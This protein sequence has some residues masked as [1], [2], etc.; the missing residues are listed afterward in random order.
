MTTNSSQMRRPDWASG[1]TLSGFVATAAMGAVFAVTYGL[2]AAVG[3]PDGGTVARWFWALGHNAMTRM[4]GDHLMLAVP[5]NLLLGLVLA[6]VY[7]RCAEPVLRGPAWRKGIAFSLLPWS[8]SIVALLPLWGG[9][10]FGMSLGAG[11]LPI[12]GNLIL[13]LVYGAV[14]GMVYALAPVAV[15]DDT[16]TGRAA[17]ATAQR[18]GAIGIGAGLAVGVAFAWMTSIQLLVPGSRDANML[19]WALVG[20]APGAALGS[21]LGMGGQ[22]GGAWRD[23]SVAPAPARIA[24]PVNATVIVGRSDV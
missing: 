10:L 23:E 15:Q 17:A 20:A 7:G 21:I 19:A 9:G 6:L 2:S 5:L 18:G 1:G 14:L 13:H 22:I 24:E 3:A 12:L 8:V 16:A 4:A 11:P